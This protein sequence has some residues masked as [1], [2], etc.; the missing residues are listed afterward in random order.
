MSGEYLVD[1]QRLS[2]KFAA[3]IRIIHV[4]KGS[5]NI[6]QEML[7]FLKCIYFGRPS[8]SVCLESDSNSQKITGALPS[9]G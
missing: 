9:G 1:D 5:I 7:A 2:V 6:Y 8:T 3:D 4:K